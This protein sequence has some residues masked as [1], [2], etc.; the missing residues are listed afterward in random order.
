MEP[1]AG[2][3][4]LSQLH[5]SVS[6]TCDFLMIHQGLTT[7]T[8]AGSVRVS[9]CGAETAVLEFSPTGTFWRRGKKQQTKKTKQSILWKTN[10]SAFFSPSSLSVPHHQVSASEPFS[11]FLLFYPFRHSSVSQLLPTYTRSLTHTHKMPP[12]SRA[13]SEQP[14]GSHTK[15]LRVEGTLDIQKHKNKIKY[16]LGKTV[17]SKITLH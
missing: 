6:P 12:G 15:S 11:R 10:R 1:S 16:K 3:P 13:G 14:C 4:R 17:V 2:H 8:L 7:N 5:F 9:L